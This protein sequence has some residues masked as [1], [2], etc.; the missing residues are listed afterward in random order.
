MKDEN[1]HLTRTN[2]HTKDKT[3][4]IIRQT[5]FPCDSG[6]AKYFFGKNVMNLLKILLTHSTHPK[7]NNA[8]KVV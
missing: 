4:Q 8:S 5:Y 2:I 6:T 3:T 1:E 7:S